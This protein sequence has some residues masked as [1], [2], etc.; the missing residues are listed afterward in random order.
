MLHGN[1][2][3][4]LAAALTGH[5]SAVVYGFLAQSREIER[6]NTTVMRAA[7]AARDEKMTLDRIHSELTALSRGYETTPQNIQ[8][9][10]VKAQELAQQAKKAQWRIQLRAV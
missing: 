4:A 10:T 8:N 7:G 2:E 9:Y 6:S 5:T 3:P 1:P